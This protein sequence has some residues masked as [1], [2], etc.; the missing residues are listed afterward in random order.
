M[1][2]ETLALS[3]QQDF[4]IALPDRPDAAQIFDALSA[5][6]NELILNDMEQLIRIL[7][8]IDVNEAK[9]RE[10]LRQHPDQDAAAI[11]SRL[12]IERQL[13]KIRLRKAG[14]KQNPGTPDGERW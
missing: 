2:E 5:K 6:I 1:E 12:I 13:Q 7:Y 11:M 4:A 9:L 3:L 14:G 10:L 8:R